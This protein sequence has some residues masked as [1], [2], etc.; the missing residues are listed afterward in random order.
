MR[1]LAVC[2]C[3]LLFIVNF[4]AHAQDDSAYRLH[5]PSAEEYLTAI[6]QIAIQQRPLLKNN[7]WVNLRLFPVI[8]HEL[9]N[10]YKPIDTVDFHR[11]WDAYHT[12][13]I[14]DDWKYANIRKQWNV[15]IIY[16]WLRQ[17][18][19]DLSK[20]SELR[21]EDYWITVTPRDYNADGLNEYLL[22]ISQGERADRL[23]CQYDKSTYVDYLVTEQVRDD[24]YF[25]E[26]PLGWFGSDRNFTDN[27]Q[28][29]VEFRFEDINA[30]GLPEWVLGEGGF[31]GGGPSVGYANSGQL[32]VLGWR[33]G[34]L[35][36][37]ASNESQNGSRSITQYEEDDGICMGAIPRDVSWEF[38]N[39]DDDPALEILQHQIYIDNWFCEARRTRILDWSAGDDRYIEK[40]E[41]LDFP[42]DT[43]NCAQRHAEEALWMGDYI[44]AIQYFEQSL[45]LPRF[46][47]HYD[48]PQDWLDSENEYVQPQLD[49]LDQYRIA[50]MALAYVMNA[51]PDKANAVISGLQSET[52]D[53][54]AV[55]SMVDALSK[56]IDDPLHAC[57]VVYNVFTQQFPDQIYGETVEQEYPN[58]HDY[59][60]ARVGCD[61]SPMIDQLLAQQKRTT[62]ETPVKMLEK[63]GLKVGDS[64]SEDLN[65]DGQ[66]EWLVWLDSLMLPIFFAPQN[67]VYVISRPAVDPYHLSDGVHTWKLPDDTG[68]G[69]VYLNKSAWAAQYGVPWACVYDNVCGVGG[70]ESQCIPGPGSELVLWRMVGQELTQILETNLCRADL[71]SLF[72]QGEGSH[73]LDGGAI[74]YPGAYSLE[75][76]SLIYRWDE[77]TLTYEPPSRPTLQPSPTAISP[78]APAY[79][80]ADDAFDA[81]DYAAALEM[82][83]TEINHITQEYPDTDPNK[84]EYLNP[85]LYSRTLILEALN[86]RDDALAEYVAIYNAAPDSAWGELA[87]LHLEKVTP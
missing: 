14:G 46:Q 43:R 31:S 39:T 63:L 26:T 11:L 34:K 56:T 70:G 38:K 82:V 41:S 45:N 47:Y 72:P 58:Y 29:L 75:T 74:S 2:L 62:D 78:E 48:W 81:G 20:V 35:I 50:R 9:F 7:E 80:S 61:V 65:G 32:F 85:S 54:E 25:L 51:Q 44:T 19:I 87:A 17:N 67:D 76:S 84:A 68:T 23:A 12:L 40:G 77:S 15:A 33:N 37:L 86:R 13:G 64:I 3:L 27:D 16:A 8:T 66:K 6:E 83:D 22:D 10:R 57:L 60:P 55:K 1:R 53:L 42:Y 59:D 69:L 24:Y 28:G 21:F 79:Q 52:F 49:K 18:K 73:V 71:D 30:D 36:D 5:T 4:P